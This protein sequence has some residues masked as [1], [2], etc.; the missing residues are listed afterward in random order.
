MN[1][2]TLAMTITNF[3]AREAHRGNIANVRLDVLADRIYRSMS[4]TN[5]AILI[6]KRMAGGMDFD[7]AKASVVAAAKAA[8]TRPY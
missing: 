4:A 2:A 6:G 7:A 8:V 1:S 5:I 3:E